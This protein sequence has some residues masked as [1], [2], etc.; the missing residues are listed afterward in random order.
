MSMINSKRQE[1][2]I[3]KNI[4]EERCKEKTFQ[5]HKNLINLMI[6]QTNDGDATTIRKLFGDVNDDFS[7][8]VSLQNS[9]VQLSLDIAKSALE[10]AFSKCSFITGSI[11]KELTDRVYS[12]ETIVGGKKKMH[13]TEDGWK[14]GEMVKNNDE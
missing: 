7:K 13:W 12:G 6:A 11:E 5:Y 2:E 1:K 14:E 3:R 9:M 10:D 4:M 8:I